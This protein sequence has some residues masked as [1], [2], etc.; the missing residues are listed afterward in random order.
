M[1]C[2]GPRAC[3]DEGKRAAEALTFDYARLGRA[4]VRVAR[5]FNTYGPNMH[6]DDGRVVSNLVCQALSGRDDHR[7]WRRHADAE[8]LLCQRHGGRAHPPDGERH[9]RMRANKPRQSGGNDGE[10]SARPHPRTSSAPTASWSTSR[11]RRTIQ[12]AGARISAVPGRCWA[13]SRRC[14]WSSGWRAPRSG[15]PRRSALRG[16]L[17]HAMAA[18]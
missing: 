14:R 9:R 11:C 3:Y 15:S 10:G 12:G 6:P 1:S 7:A 18:E 16:A 8:L 17:R 5:I 13:G 2:T 4:E